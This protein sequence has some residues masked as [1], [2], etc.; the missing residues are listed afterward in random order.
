MIMLAP[1]SRGFAWDRIELGRY[2]IDAPFISEALNFTF[3]RCLID[4]QRIALGGFSDGASYTLSL[5][6]SNGDLFTHLIAFSPGF[7]SPGGPPVGRPKI[8]ISHGVEDPVLS[9]VASRIEIVPVLLANGYDVTYE[10]FTGVHQV[11]P[12]IASL[13]LDWF[14]G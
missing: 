7:S 14:V 1:E 8:F 12:E 3:D 9:I 4:P 10:E 13:A 2:G 6:P 5:G 11:P